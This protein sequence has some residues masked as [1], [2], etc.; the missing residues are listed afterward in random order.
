MDAMSLSRILN[1]ARVEA[2]HSVDPFARHS[3]AAADDLSLIRQ[4]PGQPGW[5]QSPRL[6]RDVVASHHA[7]DPNHPEKMYGA[8][9]RGFPISVMQNSLGSRSMLTEL[10]S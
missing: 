4:R 5:R 6:G 3:V 10:V 9:G 7:Y 8:H 1:G 2:W